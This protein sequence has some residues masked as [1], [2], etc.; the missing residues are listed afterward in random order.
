M[1]IVINYGI[2]MIIVVEYGI[3]MLVSECGK[4]M[5]S[6]V[7]LI[8]AECRMNMLLLSCCFFLKSFPCRFYLYLFILY[9]FM[10]CVRL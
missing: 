5:L 6:H 4:N 2:D 3:N 7:M 1:L 8:V 9:L 10:C